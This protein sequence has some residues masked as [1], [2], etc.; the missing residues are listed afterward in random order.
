M[1]LTGYPKDIHLSFWLV[2]LISVELILS[3]L[4]DYLVTH[5]RLNTHTT[6]FFCEYSFYFQKDMLQNILIIIV[7]GHP[8]LMTTLLWQ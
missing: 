4:M 8:K 5:F 6:W 2:L 3:K 7:P 1:L